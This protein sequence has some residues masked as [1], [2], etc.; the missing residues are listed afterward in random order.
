VG[1]VL[2]EQFS[3]LRQQHQQLAGCEEHVVAVAVDPVGSE[4]DN[5]VDRQPVEPN[6]TADDSYLARKTVVVKAAA[7]LLAYCS[8]F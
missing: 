3:R 5:A 1:D 6:Q 7:K 2:L 8:S 4:F